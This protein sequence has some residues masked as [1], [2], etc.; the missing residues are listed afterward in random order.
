MDFDCDGWRWRTTRKIK[1]I[2]IGRRR[3][4]RRRVREE[5]KRR[6]EGEGHPIFVELV[7]SSYKPFPLIHLTLFH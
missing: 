7:F 1:R 2:L 5:K 3:R 6:R 4:P